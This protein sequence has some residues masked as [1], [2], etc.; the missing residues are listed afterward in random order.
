MAIK[1]IYFA[2]FDRKKKKELEKEFKI[3][4]SLYHHNLVTCYGHKTNDSMIEIYLEYMENGTL[5]ELIIE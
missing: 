4:E 5:K 3:M 1:K 2:N